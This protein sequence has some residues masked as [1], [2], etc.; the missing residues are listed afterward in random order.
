MRDPH[1]KVKLG[2]SVFV[3]GNLGVGTTLRQIVWNSSFVALPIRGVGEIYRRRS[4]R[5]VAL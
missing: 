3:V 4:R 2:M 5:P 1:F